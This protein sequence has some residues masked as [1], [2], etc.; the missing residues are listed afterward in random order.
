M[1]GPK[2]PQSLQIIPS[3]EESISDQAPLPPSIDI[4]CLPQPST[5][6]TPTDPSGTTLHKNSIKPI[7]IRTLNLVHTDATNIPP[8]PPSLTLAP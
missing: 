7:S 2:Q 6:F 4:D 3:D 5:K 8:I 1:G